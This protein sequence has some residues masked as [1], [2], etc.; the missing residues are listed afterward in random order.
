MDY[1]VNLDQA[2]AEINSRLQ[3]WTAAGLVPGPITWR[4][5]AAAWSQRLEIDRAVVADPDSVGVFLQ[6]RDEQ[7]ALNIVLYR[8]GWADVEGLIHDAIILEC[9]KIT[10][11][12]QFGGVLDTAVARFQDTD[13]PTRR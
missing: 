6:T 2:A 13:R 1:V 7:N 12:V 4:D 9:P 3:S 8:G 5:E 11:A 10:T